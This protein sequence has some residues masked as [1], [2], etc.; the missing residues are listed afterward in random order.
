MQPGT[1]WWDK[2][3]TPVI[4]LAG[5]MAIWAVAAWDARMHWPLVV[6]MAWSIAALAVCVLASFLVF[7]AML[8]NPFFSATVRIQTERNHVVVD[9]GPYRY[10]RHPGYTG[11]IVFTVVSPLALGSLYALIPATL[12][13]AVLVLRTVLEDATLRSELA[14]YA[15]YA[16]R[17]RARL[18]PCLW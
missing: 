14:G 12:T 18:I 9:R 10:V 11:A 8:V 2:I 17:V 1:K 3:L 16:A 6:G 5:P 7:R 13:A 4:A 15:E